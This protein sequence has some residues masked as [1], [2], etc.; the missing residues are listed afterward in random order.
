MSE[1]L[2]VV[3]YVNQF[4]AGIGGEEQADIPPGERSG[5]VGPGVLLQRL[6]GER[7]TVVATVWCGDNYFAQN[8]DQAVAEVLA[9]I[10]RYHP[11]VVVAGP[12]FNAGRYGPACARVVREV[13]DRLQVPAVT[14]MAPENPGV[15]LE[16]RRIVVVPTGTSAAHMAKAV[17]PL[18]EL[19]VKLG[20]RLPLGPAAQEG[21]LPRGFKR[22]ELAPET[23]AVRAVDL[24]LKK[25]QGEPYR[26]ELPLPKFD[27]VTPA[28]PVLD[29][30][31]ARVALVTEGGI[32]PKGNPD[33]LESARATKWLRYSLEGLQALSSDTHQTVHGGYN[34][35]FANVDPNRVLPLDVLRELVAEGVVGELLEAYYVT[36]GNG[37]SLENAARFG[38]DIAAELLRQGVQAAVLTST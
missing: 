23:G 16:G 22:N 17:P 34:Q 26:T 10:A 9:L 2:R 3:H 18:A 8:P 27:R 31:K 13:Q 15:E 14:A 1:T 6:L 30:R 19:A 29:L 5:P 37:T 7:G 20:R 24:L 4:F 33:R 21:Y 12:A 25:L 32:V 36:T 28:P 11:D 35:S 38:R